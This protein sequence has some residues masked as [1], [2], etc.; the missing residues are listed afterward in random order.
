MTAMSENVDSPATPAGRESNGRFARGNKFGPG[1]P[2]ARKCAALRSALVR[3]MEEEHMEKLADKL[4]A[5]ALEGDLAAARLVLQYAVGRPAAAVDPDDLERLEFEHHQQ[6]TAPLED[7]EQLLQGV[8][9][10]LDVA[11]VSLRH[12]LPCLSQT[13]ATAAEQAL[14]TGEVPPLHPDQED[15]DAPVEPQ[16]EEPAAEAQGEGPAAPQGAE[17]EVVRYPG[18]VTKRGQ[19][20]ADTVN[21]R[22]QRTGRAANAGQSKPKGRG[23]PGGP[24]E[25]RA[26]NER[27]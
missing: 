23:R 20:P 3:R 27:A 11:N 13:I 14:R 22:E 18:T 4:V 5:M 12:T 17:P 10:P 2:F 1:N 21:K 26:V 9:M 16:D 19:R 8:R 24:E 6:N 25:G 15:E 7:V